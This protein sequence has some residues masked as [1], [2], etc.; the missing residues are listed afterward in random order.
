MIF[1]F[2]S[3]NGHKKVL[4]PGGSEAQEVWQNFGGGSAA[5]RWKLKRENV[6]G[7]FSG[8]P[9]PSQHTLASSCGAW[10]LSNISLPSFLSFAGELRRGEEETARPLSSSAPPPQLLQS[11]QR[12]QWED[13]SL[14]NTHWQLYRI[15]ITNFC[16]RLLVLLVFITITVRKRYV[17]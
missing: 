17:C 2:L 1:F 12:N 3:G 9:S 10:L 16:H 8:P 14:R 6:G 11:R 5:I 15:S 13:P 7:K 4:L